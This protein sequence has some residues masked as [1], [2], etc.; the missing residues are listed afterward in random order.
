MGII[1]LVGFL[2][3]MLV[4]IVLSY[5]HSEPDSNPGEKLP[6]E[7]IAAM[8][9]AGINKHGCQMKHVGAFI[10]QLVAE[11]DNDF[12]ANAIMVVHEDGTHLGYIKKEET[13]AVREMIGKN[14]KSYTVVGEVKFVEED[15]EDDV[16]ETDENLVLVED[17]KQGFF[18]ARVYIDSA[19]L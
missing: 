2:L 18:V 11:P 7:F 5:N 19:H 14:F 3:V 9:V 15:D 12:D 16:D 6:S 8:N 13:D 4:V 17:A 1:V 10:G